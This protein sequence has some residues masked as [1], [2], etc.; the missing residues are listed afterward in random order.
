MTDPLLI[1]GSGGGARDILWLARR[2]GRD[3]L[4]LVEAD[5]SG[6]VGA[7]VNGLSV[8]SESQAAAAYAEATFIVG[9]GDC[10]IRRAVA[11]QAEALGFEAASPLVSPDVHLDPAFAIGAGSVISSGSTVTI[12]V[13]IG[14]HVHINHHCC[15]PH[16]CEISDYATLAPGVVLGGNVQIGSEAFIGLGAVVRNG[17]SEAPLRIGDSVMVGAGAVVTRDVPAGQTVIGV[18]ARSR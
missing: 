3:V 1:F 14:S 6:K 12:D 9:I 11:R 16:D 5:G 4:A 13:S 17:S 2:C 7:R 8:V 15:V 18:P 10:R